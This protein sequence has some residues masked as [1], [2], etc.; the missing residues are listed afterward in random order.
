M[1]LLIPILVVLPLIFFVGLAFYV[2]YP[3]RHTLESSRA[4]ED[5]FGSIRDF[6][7]FPSTHYTIQSYDGYEL[8]A[9]FIPASEPSDHYVILSHGYSYTRYGSVKYV[10]QFRRLNYHCII[11]DNRGHGKNVRTYCTLGARESKDLLAVIEDTYRRHGDNI[12]LGLHGESMGAGLQITALKYRPQVK[13][14]VNDCGYADLP[15]LL[16]YKGK[17]EFHLPAWPVYGASFF[18][19]L[20]FGFAFTSV[21]PIECLAQNTSIPICFV[22]GTADDFVPMAHSE[23]MYDAATCYRELHL[24]EGAGHARCLV[25][26]PE[27]YFSMLSEFLKKIETH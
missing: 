17:K 15:D 19:R 22:H 11:Y 3:K 7:T 9:Q 23:R 24:F 21:R 6:D 5:K 18:S 1:W 25:T 20:L 27:R 10:H 26:D 13:F 4:S 8:S 2:V 14:I 16:C 12:Y